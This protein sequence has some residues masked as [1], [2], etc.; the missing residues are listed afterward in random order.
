MNSTCALPL[1]TR[2]LTHLSDIRPRIGTFAVAPLA[3]E[4]IDAALGVL[5]DQY[6][7]DLSADR[8][9]PPGDADALR[10]GLARHAA[11][12]IELVDEMR[13]KLEGDYSALVV[14]SM[15]L[16]HLPLPMRSALLFALSVGLGVP[17]AT[18]RVN[19]R[20]V[21]DVKVR[22]DKVE[23]NSVSTF[24]EHPYEAE[25][26]TD[27]QYFERPERYMLLYVVVPAECGGGISSMRALQCLRE[28]LSS[29]PEG[30]W[31]MDYLTD[32]D[33]PFRI[34]AVFTRDG[35]GES[36]E[37]TFAPIFGQR[38]AIR[39]RLDTLNKG[40]ELYPE[41]DVKDLRR[42]LKVVNDA[43]CNQ[44]RLV[45]MAMPAD[46]LQLLNNHEALHGRSPF[47]DNNRHV[48]RIRIAE[49]GSLA[50]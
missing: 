19:R 43:A 9:V 46:S 27:T 28:E 22:Q 35:R 8:L 20:V 30:R 39:Y 26:H 48:L 18:D 45:T 14:P 5:K 10:A 23:N 13:D 15:G 37:V 1:R 34:P 17:T 11:Q 33:L 38:P 32:R 7:P 2:Q 40:L 41:L 42:A 12:L 36:V 24:S 50:A 16:A 31:A 3:N 25:L 44:E 21:W 49:A 6:G 29:T 4:Q 47:T